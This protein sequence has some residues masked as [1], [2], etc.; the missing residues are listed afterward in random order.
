MGKATVSYR[1]RDWLISRQRYWGAPIPIVYCPEHGAV[2]VP[3]DQLPVLLPD[4]V[5]FKPTG[6][7]PLR[8]VPE[9][10]E[11]DLPDLWRSG[12]A[13]DRHDGHVHLL[14]V[15]LP[16]LRR[17]DERR[18]AAWSAE[19]LAKWLPVDMYIG[20]PEHAT[21]HLLYAR[22]FVK[23]LRD[24]GL[25]NFDE[26]FTR[27]YHQGMVLGPD[28][29][30]MSKSRG[31]VIAPDD[32]VGRYGADTVR[33]YLMF[34]GPFD[35]GGPWNN[36]GIEGVAR[37]MN[38]VWTLVT[39]ATEAQACAVTRGRSRRRGAERRA[40]APQGHR[41][42]DGGL[43]GAALQHG[44]GGADGVRQRAEQGAR[45]GAGGRARRGVLARRWIRCWCCWRQW[46]R[47]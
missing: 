36:Q 13:R 35:Q 19:K 14:V 39:D 6:E 28:G 18:S 30:K 11:H 46:R 5:E 26:P 34:M 23:A 21:L 29:Q 4:E 37:F 40:A 32:V 25:L 12:H 16:A 38:R 10:F 44:A 47:I 15:V 24:M 27:L 20:G 7:S 43:R 1:L 31:N 41:A 8:Y 42:R 3:E 17:P 9:F 33:C 22:F 45:G 2:P